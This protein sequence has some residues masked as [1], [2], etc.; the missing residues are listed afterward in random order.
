MV[1]ALVLSSNERYA[2]IKTAAAETAR[3]AADSKFN[4]KL[5]EIIVTSKFLQELAQIKAM[6]LTRLSE[7]S[8]GVLD[9]IFPAKA[10]KKS[11]GAKKDPNLVHHEEMK[12]GK[13]AG[14][15]KSDDDD[16][17]DLQKFAEDF[18]EEELD[19]REWKAL[20]DSQIIS[21]IRLGAGLAFL[22]I[23]LNGMGDDLLSD[24]PSA[25]LMWQLGALS[26]AVNLIDEEQG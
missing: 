15:K 3:R 1:T 2:K 23:A 8:N 21:G 12:W 24:V 26:A 11:G 5:A 13:K 18:D 20:R 22:S 25:L 16:K 17:M 10:E 14:G 9:K 19:W 4:K 7:F 6:F